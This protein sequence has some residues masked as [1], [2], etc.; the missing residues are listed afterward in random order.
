MQTDLI[1]QLSADLRAVRPRSPWR[2]A[3][4]LFAVAASQ[5]ALFLWLGAGRDDMHHAA[6][7]PGFWW[8]LSSLGLLAVLGAITAL[9]SFDPAANPRRGLR[10]ALALIS[11]ALVAGW[12]VDLIANDRGMI[13]ARLDWRLGV[14]CVI[15][16][17]VMTL[18]ALVTLGLLMRRGASTH[19]RGTSVAVGLA[20]AAW[21]AFVF[22]FACP[23]DD[24]LYVAVWYGVSIACITMASRVV[25]PKIASW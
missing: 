23:S 14:R 6:G 7:H 13:L 19:L 2:D 1:D 3:A 5:L 22:A 15:E 10:H 12:A 20:G 21:G 17:V 25:L 9:R 4:V 24:P 18:P 8:K 16:T 11:V